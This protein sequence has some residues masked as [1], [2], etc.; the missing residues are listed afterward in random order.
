MGQYLQ[1]SG[2]AISKNEEARNLVNNLRNKLTIEMLF[3]CFKYYM[4]DVYP[5]EEMSWEE[6]DQIFSPALNN[7]Q[8][9]FQALSENGSANIYEVFITSAIF[10]KNV[11]YEDKLLCIFK[12]SCQGLQLYFRYKIHSIQKWIN[13]LI[14]FFKD[15]NKNL[16]ILRYP[17]KVNFFFTIFTLFENHS[18]CRI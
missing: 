16:N 10:S 18:K 15:P 2:Q 6:F 8:P 5:R 9:L 4:Q 11:E 17:R 13:C 14:L 12:A 3:E 7:C 1:T